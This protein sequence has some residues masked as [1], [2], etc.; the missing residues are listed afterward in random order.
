MVL[1]LVIHMLQTSSV[2]V[3]LQIG[4]YNPNWF[5]IEFLA[6]EGVHEVFGFCNREKK[7]TPYYL[8]CTEYDI[9]TNYCVRVV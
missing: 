9:R 3:L 8:G 6:Q 4:L 2:F 7:Y 1:K 5:F